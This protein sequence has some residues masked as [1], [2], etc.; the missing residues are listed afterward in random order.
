MCCGDRKVQHTTLLNA[1]LH[2]SE[3]ETN[4]NGGAS[5]PSCIHCFLCVWIKKKGRSLSFYRVCQ[6]EHYWRRWF[7]VSFLFP[8]LRKVLFWEDAIPFG[9]LF[10]FTHT[11]V[12]LSLIIVINEV[13]EWRVTLLSFLSISL[14]KESV[15]ESFCYWFSEKTS[16]QSS[17]CN[18][19]RVAH[20]SN[21][22]CPDWV[23]SPF[24]SLS[25][26]ELT[27][28]TFVTSSLNVMRMFTLTDTLDLN[29]K[30]FLSKV[31]LELDRPK[32]VY[33]CFPYSKQ[34]CWNS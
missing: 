4:V 26:M 25:S 8:F 29:C 11:L 30:N 22:I 15:K 12:S 33:N 23:S 32:A 17:R 31:I 13:N 1:H 28:I 20:L 6:T 21:S 19:V 5:S 10:D 24:P 27:C 16:S 18:H 2:L 14:C 9:P 34:R 7:D 3:R